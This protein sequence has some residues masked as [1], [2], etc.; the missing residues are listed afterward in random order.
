MQKYNKKRTMAT[1]GNY[2]TTE[3]REEW[4]GVLEMAVMSSDS[5][6]EEDGEEVILVH[7]LSWI[8]DD[9][10]S[11]KNKLDEQIKNEKSPQ[12]QQQMKCRVICPASTNPCP[13][14]L[15]LPSSALA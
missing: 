3:E 14:S 9:V 8:S 10:K 7:P 15:V 5:S 12:T 6:G 2:S 11:F 1:K 4:L 13:T